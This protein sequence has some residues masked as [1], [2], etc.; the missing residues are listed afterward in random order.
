MSLWSWIKAKLFPAPKPPP[1]KVVTSSFEADPADLVF[2]IDYSISEWKD[3]RGASWA[4]ITVLK[5]TFKD[6]EFKFNEVGLVEHDPNGAHLSMDYDFINLTEKERTLLGKSK[7]FNNLV[8]NIAFS[9]LMMQ[10]LKKEENDKDGDTRGN[11]SG[12]PD[13][14]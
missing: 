6:I 10:A 14:E 12:E 2:G 3:V 13:S 7:D 5:G 4:K 9:I 11:D 8:F 1:P